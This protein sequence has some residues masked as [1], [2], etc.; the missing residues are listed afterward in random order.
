MAADPGGNTMSLIRRLLLIGAI[1]VIAVTPAFGQEVPGGEAVAGLYYLMLGAALVG[2][3][4]FAITLQA[5]AKKTGTPN[6][7][8]GWIP[9][10]NIVLSLNIARKPLWWIIL[11]LI[12]F[13]NLIMFILVWMGIAKSRNRPSWWGILV[14]VP[15]V[16]LVILGILAWS[17]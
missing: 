15:V 8:W 5:I 1:F 11:C 14:L 17:A 7:W 10:L 6:G 9:I 2:Y 13:L 12:P 4:Y 3:I 16:N